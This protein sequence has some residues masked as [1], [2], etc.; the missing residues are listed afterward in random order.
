MTELR[1]LLIGDY[2]VVF[3]NGDVQYGRFHSLAGLNELFRSNGVAAQWPTYDLREPRPKNEIDKL[4]RMLK[5]AS[6]VFVPGA[7]GIFDNDLL[8]DLLHAR[9][10]EGLRIWITVPQIRPEN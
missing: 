4:Q 9:L 2:D 8:V 3:A 7:C 1:P 6:A 10:N 5:R